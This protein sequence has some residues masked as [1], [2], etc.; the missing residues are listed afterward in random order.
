M[1]GQ[2]WEAHSKTGRKI[3][4][5]F[6]LLPSSQ[7]YSQKIYEYKPFVVAKKKAQL[8]LYR[9][10]FYFFNVSMAEVY[11]IRCTFNIEIF[12]TED[13]MGITLDGVRK[14]GC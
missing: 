12:C 13:C 1:T 7:I 11:Q 2:G 10:V 8:I 5:N 6:R 4:N 14:E 3:L 9:G